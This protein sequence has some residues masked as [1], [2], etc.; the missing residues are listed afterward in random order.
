MKTQDRKKYILEKLHSSD[1]PISAST[2]GKELAVSRQ[3]IVGDVSLLRAAGENIIATPRGYIIEKF[4]NIKYLIVCKHSR[5]QLL[6]ELYTIVDNG[7]AIIDVIVEHSIY[8]QISGQLH[9]F[10]RKDADIFAEQINKNNENLLSNLTNEIHFHTL[11]C[12]SE[13]YFE[14]TKMALK[15]KGYLIDK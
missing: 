13:K 9:I 3:V 11:H 12:P 5:E 6:D 14:Q 2:F 4:N 10:N 15:E 1:E 7:C 8:G